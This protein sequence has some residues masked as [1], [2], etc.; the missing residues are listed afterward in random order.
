VTVGTLRGRSRQIAFVALYACGIVA[1]VLGGLRFVDS[2]L[3]A[4]TADELVR[5]P[6]A[7]R[8]V[9]TVELFPFDG[10]HV[11]ANFH[12]RGPMPWNDYTPDADFDI[13]TG[14]KGYFVDFP[15]E[16]PPPKAANEF[17]IVLIGGSGAQGWGATRN[18]KMFYRLLENELNRRYAGRGI[19][20]RV[21]NL[22]MGTSFTYQNFI[23]LNQWGH[24]LEPDLIL[25]YVGRNDFFV[26]LYHENMSDRFLYSRD[27][28]AFAIASRGSE[29]PPGMQWLFDLMPN[30]MRRTS[31]GLGIKVAFGWDHFKRRSIE[32]Y[33]KA[34][35][36]KIYS[37][38][39]ALDGLATPLLVHALK[40][41]KRDFEGVPIMVAWQAVDKEMGILQRKNII[42]GPGFYD[43]MYER[44]RSE[45]GGYLNDQWYFFNVHRVA[46]EQ[47]RLGLQTHL[48]DSAHQVV[49][50]LLAGRVDQVMPALLEERARRVA[51][52]LPAGYGR[53]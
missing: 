28:G 27:L 25:A 22:A 44:C 35:G 20:V 7:E 3:R 5:D 43:H 51:R 34:R 41:I 2:R 38:E 23:A 29:V 9:N 11:Q 36:L 37:T 14:D 17:R 26:P 47:P 8:T 15:L 49:G 4:R 18:E 13:R 10:M 30:T 21:V 39:Q 50:L 52:G 31:L 53:E 16:N 45:L 42:S 12:H 32:S 33:Q 24:A 6:Y 48:S 46:E 19:R 40:S 1:L